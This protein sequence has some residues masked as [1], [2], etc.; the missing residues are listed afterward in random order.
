MYRKSSHGGQHADKTSSLISSASAV[1]TR[2]SAVPL[3]K[4]TSAVATQYATVPVSSVVNEEVIVS[5]VRKP[6]VESVRPQVS[7]HIYFSPA[8][9]VLVTSTDR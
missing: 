3:S 1:E 2:Y 5:P 9:R 6:V 7:S 8:V 4:S